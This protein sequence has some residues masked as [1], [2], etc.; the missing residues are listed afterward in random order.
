MR[1]KL[2]H[3]I[4]M[5]PDSGKPARLSRGGRDGLARAQA[6]IGLH[7]IIIAELTDRSYVQMSGEVDKTI[8]GEAHLDKRS[9]VCCRRVGQTT[10]MGATKEMGWKRMLVAQ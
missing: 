7:L 5:T 1:A 9:R 8:H 10:E 6:G 2:K 4:E 3:P